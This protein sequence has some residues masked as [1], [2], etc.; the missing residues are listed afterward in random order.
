VEEVF[1][2]RLWEAMPLRADRVLNRLADIRGGRLDES[3][4][5]E[6]MRGHGPYWDAICS[7]FA[8]SMK[9][10]GLEGGS[11][12][13]PAPTAPYL[14]AARDPLPHN[15]A[16]GNAQPSTLTRNEARTCAPKDS[17]LSFEFRD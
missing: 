6:R 16:P 5:G 7:L 17:Q 8:V 11:V 10:Y 4:F 14:P 13:E 15:A 2:K 1:V 9:R 12:A 3:R